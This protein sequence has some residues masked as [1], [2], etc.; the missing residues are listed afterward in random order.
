MS[1]NHFESNQIVSQLGK[2]CQPVTPN[3]TAKMNNKS[4][5]KKKIQYKLI[6]L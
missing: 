6:R 3:S 2:L 5:F 4:S 1:I